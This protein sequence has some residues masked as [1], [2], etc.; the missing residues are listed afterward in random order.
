MSNQKPEYSR[1]GFLTT[2]A[3]IAATAGLAGVSP[4]LALAQAKEEENEKKPGEII[5]R[6]LGRTGMKLPIVSMGAM[7]ANN[8]EIL[9]AVG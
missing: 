7:N 8:P 2:A 6:T 9:A 5:Y 4:Q 3:T 1:R